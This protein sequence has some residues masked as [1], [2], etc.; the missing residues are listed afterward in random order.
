MIRPFI[1]A[2][3]ALPILSACE[4]VVAVDAPVSTAAARTVV[5]PIVAEQVP[6]PVGAA[7]TDCIIENA[8]ASELATISAANAGA[9]SAE[10]VALVS[11]ILARDET[12]ACATA[13]LT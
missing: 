12:V 1:L 5:A 7:L 10:V 9:P 8:S 6:G 13:S 3:T 11:E 2:A 4:P